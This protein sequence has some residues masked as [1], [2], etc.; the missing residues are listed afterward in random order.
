[1]S[2]LKTSLIL[3]FS[4]LASLQANQANPF[5][6]IQA[7]VKDRSHADLVYEKEMAT[8]EKTKSIVTK[9][10]NKP[11]TVSTAVQ[12]ALL[13]NRELQATFSEFGIAQADLIEAVMLPNP[14]IN[15]EVQ[16]PNSGTSYNRYMW[17]IAQDFVQVLMTPLKKKIAT[18][19]LEAVQ[20]HVASE[21]LTLVANVKAAYFSYQAGQQLLK[22]LE[23]IQKTNAA[24]LE[25]AQQQ[26]KAGNNTDLAL[27]QAQ[28]NYSQGK[29]DLLKAE[30]ELRAQ[31]EKMNRLLGL[32]GNETAWKI[33]GAVMPVANID[34][35]TEHLESL[36]VAQRLDLRAAHR[37]L[38]S[39]ISAL[40][41]TKTYRWT[42]VLNIGFVSERDIE[43]AQNMGP[44]F[45]LELPIFNQGQGRIARGEA[46]LRMA[47]NKC[48]SLAVNIRSEVRELRNRLISLASTAHYYRDDLL[49]MRL[50]IVNKALL[51]Y[52]AMQI[53]P[54]ELFTIKAQEFEIER[55]YITTL[56]DYWV[57]R[58]E[59]ERVVGGRLTGLQQQQPKQ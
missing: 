8:R 28:S 49:P 12:I 30:T 25:L 46:Q 31:E 22:Q 27:L 38:T 58:A 48:E 20:W 4:V 41:L 45:S 32:W 54:Y 33:Q 3:F 5:Q 53:S 21:A 18:E 11:L 57:T 9:L 56:R 39:I 47:E 59:L 6:K 34:F 35:N 55:D 29:I 14:A 2:V 13:N 1:M 43:P 15:F 7:E 16:F 24:T 52:N 36:A 10:L 37:E 51:Q 19:R 50:A 44:S 17:F 23:S 42:P 26:F 40:G